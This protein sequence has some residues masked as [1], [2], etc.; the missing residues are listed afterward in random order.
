MYFE[1]CDM[2]KLSH[3]TRHTSFWIVIDQLSPL[4]RDISKSRFP[5]HLQPE[6]FET[7]NLESG[8]RNL[9]FGLWNLHIKTSSSNTRK[10]R[11]VAFT[12]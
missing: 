12:F 3:Q 5:A 7:V 10:L 4:A 8:I 11:W 9:E 6:E 1:T 2:L